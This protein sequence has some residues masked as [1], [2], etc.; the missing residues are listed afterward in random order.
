M[1]LISSSIPCRTPLHL[2][3]SPLSLTHCILH[4]SLAYG[5]TCLPGDHSSQY[6]NMLVR[7]QCLLREETFPRS[8][9]CLYPLLPTPT[10]ASLFWKEKKKPHKLAF[11]LFSIHSHVN[12]L[13]ISLFSTWTRSNWAIVPKLK[14]LFFR[15]KLILFTGCV[16]AFVSGFIFLS[17]VVFQ[18]AHHAPLS[19]FSVNPILFQLLPLQF[20]LLCLSLVLLRLTPFKK[21]IFK[22]SFLSLWHLSGHPSPWLT[23][24][25]TKSSTFLI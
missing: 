23:I 5:N 25:M 21:R 20:C 11:I 2:P 24:S 1:N 16:S 10:P 4:V 3:A 19:A 6:T 17:L 13:N 14:H 7:R 12:S 8:C 15:V 9:I 22:A 18:T